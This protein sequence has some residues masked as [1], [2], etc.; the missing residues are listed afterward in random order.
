MVL[1]VINSVWEALGSQKLCGYQ[2]HP[3]SRFSA[4]IVSRPKQE[5]K[6]GQGV[7]RAAVDLLIKIEKDLCSV[8]GAL[9]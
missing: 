1:S 3:Q 6:L 5:R 9:R 7:N 8:G 4:L 2:N